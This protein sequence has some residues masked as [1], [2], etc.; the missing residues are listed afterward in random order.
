MSVQETHLTNYDSLEQL[1]DKYN[2]VVNPANSLFLL[3]RTV[4]EIRDALAHG[5]VMSRTSNP[6]LRIFKFNRPNRGNVDVVRPNNGSAVVCDTSG[7]FVFDQ[8]EKVRSY[9]KQLGFQS[10]S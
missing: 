1:I 2:N 10:L 6:P 5:R 4:V 3:D 8:I 7:K 9:G